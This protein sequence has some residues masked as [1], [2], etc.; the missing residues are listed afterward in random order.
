MHI[1]RLEG[2]SLMHIEIHIFPDSLP[3]DSTSW[4]LEMVKLE[5]RI[6]K[7]VFDGT[8]NAKSYAMGKTTL[9]ANDDDPN[10]GMILATIDIRR[11]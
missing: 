7:T 2:T 11:S 9:L 10:A 3:I 4:Q 5:Q 8:V 6:F 1:T